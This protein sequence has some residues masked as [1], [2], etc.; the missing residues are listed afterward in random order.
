VWPA[1]FSTGASAVH[2]AVGAQRVEIDSTSVEIV[3]RHWADALDAAIALQPRRPGAPMHVVVSEHWLACAVL[4]WSGALGGAGAESFARARLGAAGFD[5]AADALVRLDDAPFG[6]PRLAVAYP[7]ALV[8]A[9]EEAARALG[10]SLAG[11]LPLGAAAWR[12]HRLHGEALAVLD[13]AALTVLHGNARWIGHLSIRAAQPTWAAVRT[14]WRR[15]RLRDVQLA[16][17]ER[18]CVLDLAGELP[19]NDEPELRRLAAPQ[20]GLAGVAR[21]AGAL[22]S[23]LDALDA[24]PRAKARHWLA[25]ACAAAAAGVLVLQAWQVHDE[26]QA[27]SASPARPAAPAHESVPWT[28]EDLARV[29]SVNAAVRELNLPIAGLLAALQPPRDVRVAVLAVDVLGSAQQDGASMVRIAAEAPSGIDMAR[30]TRH[31]VDE[32]AADKPYRFTLEATWR[33]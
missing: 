27:R 2:V 11:I 3:D 21:A 1:R 4:P 17:R 26:L 20:A 6:A 7:R 10:A 9:L 29:Q 18:L 5:V 16:A 23:P 31:E 30:L 12:V 19:A 15:L 14:Q 22:R 32:S 25:A 24:R 28:R 33:E 13:A 8:A